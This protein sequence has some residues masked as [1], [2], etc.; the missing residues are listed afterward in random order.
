MMTGFSTMPLRLAS[1]VGFGFSLF[2]FGVLV[3]IIGRYLIQG[4]SVPGFPFLAAVIS[5]F[6]GVQLFSLGIIGE[7]LA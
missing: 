4:S 7:Y 6:S 1:V 5:I 3:Y 2:G